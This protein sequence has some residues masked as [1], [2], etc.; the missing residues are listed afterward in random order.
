MSEAHG[1]PI[2]DAAETDPAALN[3]SEDLD[4]DRLRV[5]PLEEGVEPP[6]RYAHSDGFGTTPRE[7]YEGEPLDSR[8][9]QERADVQPDRIP[10]RPIA[11]TPAD[12]LD[13]SIEDLPADDEPIVRENTVDIS[14]SPEEEQADRAGGSVADALRTPPNRA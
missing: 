6:E 4:E 7:E 14:S 1:E 10:D 13:E 2:P 12:E 9:D 5:D 3:S 8:L 11:V